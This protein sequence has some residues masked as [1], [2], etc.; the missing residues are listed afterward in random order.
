LV[1]ELGYDVLLYENIEDGHGGAADNKHAGLAMPEHLFH[2]DSLA[3]VGEIH[4]GS[5]D[6][7]QVWQ[8]DRY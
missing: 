5:R 7:G 6:D 2:V 8:L 1:A 4:F 3:Q